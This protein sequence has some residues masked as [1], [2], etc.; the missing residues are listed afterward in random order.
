MTHQASGHLFLCPGKVK[1]DCLGDPTHCRLGEPQEAPSFDWGC[2]FTLTT[3][4]SPSFRST[5]LSLSPSSSLPVLP[6]LCSRAPCSGASALLCVLGFVL[7]GVSDASL[8]PRLFCFLLRPSEAA[9]APC[10]FSL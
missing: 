6:I 7:F 10:P 9:P 5:H 1:G 8:F 4:P 2:V 3:R